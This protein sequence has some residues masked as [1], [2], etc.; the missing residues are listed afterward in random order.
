MFKKWI[1]IIGLALIFSLAISSLAS[2]GGEHQW[3]VAF[4][5]VYYGYEPVNF[6]EWSG[7]A[8]ILTMEVFRDSLYLCV[9][10]LNGGQLYRSPDGAAW[11]AVGEPGLGIDILGCSDMTVYHD[12]LYVTSFFAPYILR[13]ADGLTFEIVSDPEQGSPVLSPGKLEEF[14]GMLYV[15]SSDEDGYAELWR[16]KSGDAGTWEPAGDLG[17]YL[18]GND[19]KPYK[20]MLY[21]SIIDPNY[22]TVKILRSRDSLVWNVVVDDAFQSVSQDGTNNQGG[23]FYV[24]Q[25]KLYFTTF[26]WSL[27]PVDPE[28]DWIPNGG[29]IYTT[30]NGTDWE[31]LMQGGFDDPNNVYVQGLSSYLGD[32]YGW[33]ENWE[34]GCE[35]WKSHT[36]EVG[37]W[38]QVNQDGF[39]FG[40]RFGVSQG[41]TAQVIFKDELYIAGWDTS[42]AFLGMVWKLAHP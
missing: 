21:V 3:K 22:L 9:I 42:E 28:G 16:S 27:N 39:G 33:T 35:V 15:S 30:R 2:A 19:F 12:M 7:G 1:F 17:E 25:G 26:N 23:D 29:R 18:M 36:G 6:D 10:S 38:M 13:S 4:D 40:P 31:I 24:H 8:Q 37:T 20:G 41:D 14:K 34:T 11:Q 5:P 32:L